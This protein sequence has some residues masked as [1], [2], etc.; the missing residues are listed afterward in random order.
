MSLPTFL[1][2]HVGSHLSPL[3]PG[4]ATYASPLLSLLHTPN[5]CL[6]AR[7]HNPGTPR[8]QP[9]LT[10]QG[11]PPNSHITSP[12]PPPTP[13]GGSSNHSSTQPPRHRGHLTLSHSAYTRAQPSPQKSPLSQT[14]LAALISYPYSLPTSLPPTSTSIYGCVIPHPRFITNPSP[15]L[16]LPNGI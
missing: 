11:S 4:G 7:N 9:S 2:P 3:F 15:S 10:L 13:V 14:S 12:F 6:P 16:Y 1:P 5:F 8:L